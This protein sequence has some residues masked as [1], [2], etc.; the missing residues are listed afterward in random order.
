M[1][2]YTVK[3]KIKTIFGVDAVYMWWDRRCTI[4]ESSGVPPYRRTVP[5]E[6]A[7]IPTWRSR[8]AQKILTWL[9]I[10]FLLP[11]VSNSAWI[12]PG[13]RD[14]RKHGG[15]GGFMYVARGKHPCWV[16]AFQMRCVGGGDSLSK[17]LPMLYKEAQ[18]SHVFPQ[19]KLWQ[20]C[21]SVYC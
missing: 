6:H 1:M 7:N 17:P 18:E 15:V 5:G 9:S 13:L 4:L 14:A 12:S 11:A 19:C 3:W 20:N 2:A 21:A 16:K 8:E 10:L